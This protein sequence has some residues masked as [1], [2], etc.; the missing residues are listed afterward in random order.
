VS[1]AS[2][3]GY[4]GVAGHWDEMALPSGELRPHWRR[5]MSAV[6]GLGRDEA[7]RRW[8]QAE[9]L[10]REN[11]VTYNV[12]G[13]PLGMDRPW[14]L[15]PLP[16]LIPI[17]EWSAIEAAVTQRATL[18]DRMLADLYGAQRLLREGHLPAELVFADAGFLRPCHGLAVPND[19]RLHL[20]AADLARSPDGQWWVLADRTQAPSGAGYALE[21]RVVTTRVLPEV[22]GGF[23]VPRLAGWF[24]T[25]RDSLSALAAGRTD[26]PRIVLLTPGPYNET[27]F[28]HAYLAR[29]LGVTLVE[30]ADLAVR[31]ERVHLKTLDGLLPVDVILR[32]QDDRWCDPLELFGESALGVPGLVQAVRAGHVAVANALGS[33]LVDTP[34][35]MAFLPGLCRRLLAEELRMPSVATWWCGQ[36]RELAYVENHFDG[37]VLKNTFRSSAPDVV[38]G[39]HLAGDERTAFLARLRADP[40]R[41]VAQEQVALSTVPAAASE[42]PAPRH[43]VLRV[44][45]V[46]SNGSWSVMPGGLTR[47]SA[48]ADDLVV[49]SQRGGA[50]KDTWVL[51]DAPVPVVSLMDRVQAPIDVSRAGFALTS[52]VADNLLWLGRTAERVEAGVRLFRSA[53]GRLAEE[54][55][56]AADATLPDAVELLARR[57]RLDAHEE[58]APLAE[59]IVAAI[60]D[61]ERPDS[62]SSAAHQLHHLAWLVRDRIS[63]DAWRILGRF[64]ERFEEPAGLHPALRVNAAL[65][66]LDGALLLLSAFTGLVMEGMTRALGWTFLDIGRR[67]ERAIQ[68]VEL[69]LY[70]LVEPGPREWRRLENVL[71]V[72]DS[73]MTYRSRY[74]TSLQ[75][76]LV[77]D[78]LLRDE[79]NPRSVSFQLAHL[80]RHFEPLD[81]A[82]RAAVTRLLASVRRAPLDELAALDDGGRR[83]ALEALLMQLRR[84]VPAIFAALSHAYLSHAVSKRQTPGPRGK[85]RA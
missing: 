84:D 19:V 3:L 62:L 68:M 67:L 9:R 38:F 21:N 4:A 45:A 65:D 61:R 36:Q 28:E 69:L 71:Q 55:L 23:H 60:F 43:L 12:Y 29:Y 26:S 75:A 53:L 85:A 72:A 39:A 13:D 81:K 78:L 82:P 2:G 56:R 42:G 5:L 58:E 41:W 18:L 47:V 74:Q 64:E 35:V 73:V 40:H 10:I 17:G 11:G 22:F 70:G 30:G 66:R 7:L 44:F 57:Y 32:R 52:R 27:Y 6:T 8:R 31:G 48:S 46:A 14:Q 63:T 50:S 79:A 33:G 34:G 80:E 77:L 24:Q 83:V 54:P 20:Y 76:P 59:R 1:S 25:M 15:D 49:S 16:L 37:L 51:A